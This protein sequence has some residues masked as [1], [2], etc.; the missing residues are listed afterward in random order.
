MNFKPVSTAMV[1]VAATAVVAT[2][3]SYLFVAHAD[4]EETS[5]VADADGETPETNSDEWSVSDGVSV[6]YQ[7]VLQR[8]GGDPVGGVL[9]LTFKLYRSSMSAEPL[10]S[11]DHYVSVVDGVYQVAL[12]SDSPLPEHLL[13][14]ERW[15]GVEL[16]GEDEILR[17]QITID[18]PE[19]H[20]YEELEPGEHLSR[21]DVAD[22]AVEAERA[23]VAETAES[24][25]GMTADELEEQSGLA[26]QRLNEHI[27]DPDAHSVA[28]G[29]T[30]GATRRSAGD[31]AGGAG[32]SS[33][34]I[35]CPEGYVATGIR[36][37]AGRVVDSITL[38]CSP[39]E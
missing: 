17:D 35:L 23:R 14:G 28:A 11:E 21:A 19:G 32:G 13:M 33:Y 26:I 16:Q 38:L 37:G 31:E 20:H 39:L 15:L 30:V 27:A 24:V 36:G 12:G 1:V 18:H 4:A 9:P 10:W 34:E 5:T 22:M 6:I 2:G 29:P 8:E 3:T 25:G 7:G